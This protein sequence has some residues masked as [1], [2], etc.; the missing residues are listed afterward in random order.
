SSSAKWP[1]TRGVIARTQARVSMSAMSTVARSFTAS[2]SVVR[3]EAES[4]SYCWA[5][6]RAAG[7]PAATPPPTQAALPPPAP[8]P[9]LAHVARR[10]GH[11]TLRRRRVAPVVVLD[12]PFLQPALAHDDAMRDA[13]EL[14]VGEQHA[15][16]LVAVVEQHLHAR[17]LERRVD[18][19]RGLLHRL[20]L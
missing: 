8:L 16:A 7:G 15:G 2:A 6:A 1:C 5:P 3:T 10:I 13:D 19:V 11:R 20:A 18:V 12:H 17:R 9:P 4:S 14:L